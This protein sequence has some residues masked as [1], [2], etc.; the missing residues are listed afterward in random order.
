MSER[1]KPLDHS[2]QESKSCII[3]LIQPVICRSF[4][5]NVSKQSILTS[6]ALV[7]LYAGSNVCFSRARESQNGSYSR[8]LL[9]CYT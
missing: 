5:Q 4:D 1:V 8:G 6:F 2:E 3:A 7:L 9:L